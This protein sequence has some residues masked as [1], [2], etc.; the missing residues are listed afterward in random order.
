MSVIEKGNE[1]NFFLRRELR[2]NMPEPEKRLWYHLRSRQIGGFKF[3]RQHGVGPY[4]VDFY[5]PERRFVV[6]VDGD[7][8]AEEK[9]IKKDVRR[10]KYLNSLGVVVVRYT[11]KEVMQ[12]LE[13]VL[14]DIKNKL[15]G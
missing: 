12:D 15:E 9:Q 1:L 14:I 6:E 7:S 8:H 4:I 10:T 13:G 5:C 3:R 2:K 11:N